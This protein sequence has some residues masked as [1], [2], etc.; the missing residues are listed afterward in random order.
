MGDE[1]QASEHVLTITTLHEMSGWQCRKTQPW[2]ENEVVASDVG[3]ALV[4]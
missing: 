3:V 4:L 2:E 1:T